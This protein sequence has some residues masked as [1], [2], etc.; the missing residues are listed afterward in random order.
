MLTWNMTAS[1]WAPTLA[2]ALSE[3]IWNGSSSSS[4][5]VL[6]LLSLPPPVSACSSC[7]FDGVLYEEEEEV[8]KSGEQP[9]LLEQRH[10]HGLLQQA[11]RGAAQ[12]DTHS[13]E[14]GTNSWLT[15]SITV[16]HCTQKWGEGRLLD[17]SLSVSRMVLMSMETT[18]CPISP[19]SKPQGRLECTWAWRCI[20][21]IYR[22]AT[23]KKQIA[24][25]PAGYLLRLLVSTWKY[26]PISTFLLLLSWM[27]MFGF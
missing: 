6:T 5:S 20:K 26:H 7:A 3:P 23:G 16:Q 25:S 21:T 24:N 4:V 15:D 1:T 8:V 10:H 17:I 27:Y 22:D 9:Q 13:G 19:V 2:W 12:R 11:R 18:R 14:W